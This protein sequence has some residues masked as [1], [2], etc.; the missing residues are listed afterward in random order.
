MYYHEFSAADRRQPPSGD[1]SGAVERFSAAR[2]A[3]RDDPA[4]RGVP[5]CVSGHGL[6]DFAAYIHLLADAVADTPPDEE[7]LRAAVPASPGLARP[8]RG[9]L[10]WR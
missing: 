10:T 2:V 7:S 8:V 6:L 3:T 1:L 5:V 9:D 4:G